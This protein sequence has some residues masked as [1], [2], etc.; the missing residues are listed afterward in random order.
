MP[1]LT[2]LVEE[3]QRILPE[4]MIKPYSATFNPISY[5]FYQCIYIPTVEILSKKYV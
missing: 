1:F 4:C 3:L 5:D 2:E